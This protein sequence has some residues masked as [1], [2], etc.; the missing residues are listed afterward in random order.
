[1][2]G[3]KDGY[4]S[5]ETLIQ[6]PVQPYICFV[7]SLCPTKD[8]L[9]FLGALFFVDMHGLITPSMRKSGPYFC[10]NIHF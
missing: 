1:M 5:C 2:Y 6:E 4:I 10:E 3:F 9:H 8:L 7:V